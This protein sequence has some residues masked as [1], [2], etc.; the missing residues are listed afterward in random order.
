MSNYS[1]HKTQVYGVETHRLMG[2]KGDSMR[3][4]EVWN[5]KGLNFTISLDRCAD[6]SR[7]FYKGINMGYMSPVGYVHP[8]YYNKDEFLRS[9]TAGFLT[10]CGLN[11]VGSPN[12]DE[13][14][15]LP[16]HGTISNIPADS[17]KVNYYKDRIEILATITDEE[18]FSHKLVLNRTIIVSLK[19]NKIIIK[20]KIIN[21]GDKEYPVEILYHMN[22][23]YPLLSEDSELYINSSNV[24]PRNEFAAQGINEWNKISAPIAGIEEQCYFHEFEKNEGFAAIFNKKVHTGLKISFDS[25]NLK[26]FTEWKMMGERDYVLGLEP[27]NCH[28][29]GRNK[30]RKENA[31]TILKPNESV[32]YVVN[33]D[34][35]SSYEKFKKLK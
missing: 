32:E 33:V 30:M 23:G 25:N 6:I 34:F 27:G 5:G 15:N 7:L 28:P 18:I 26:Y 21:N 1:G 4:L 17:Y 8:S 20:D 19:T 11:N 31:L 16:L 13:G 29:D 22:M 3:L 10:T 12:V 35:F 24:K 9:F 2:G 14:E